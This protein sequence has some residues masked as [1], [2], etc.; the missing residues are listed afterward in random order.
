MKLNMKELMITGVLLIGLAMLPMS[1]KANLVRE[2]TVNVVAQDSAQVDSFL[3]DSDKMNSVG[4]FVRNDRY[5]GGGSDFQNFC[6]D[7]ILPLFLCVLLPF[8]IVFLC[9]YF[10]RKREKERNNMLLAMIDK[11][12]DVKEFIAA[13]KSSEPK[14]KRGKEY[15][16][17]IWGMILFLFGLGALLS[18][19]FTK[20]NHVGIDLP[21]L[22]IGLA[23]IIVAL[24]VRHWSKKDDK[25]KIDKD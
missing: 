14:K 21:V 8:G 11:G 23:L 7:V 6:E 18:E 16:L 4:D 10:K 24:I 17:M 9:L 13:E 25:E 1:S 19:P 20:A 15:G 3:A 2:K 5:D 22:G 12:I